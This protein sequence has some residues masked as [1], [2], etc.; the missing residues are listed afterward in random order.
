MT[1]LS[2][3]SILVVDPNGEAGFDLSQSLLSA[4][5]KTHVVQSLNA[6]MTLLNAKR[7]DAV[8]LPYSREPQ[9]VTFCMDLNTRSIPTVFTSEP[10][11]RYPVR[12]RMSG[13]IAAV[14]NLIA[15][16]SDKPELASNLIN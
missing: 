2:N 8:V 3:L 10:P 7:V 11:T 13:A 15:D 4:G 14:Q 6:A 12:R 5:A 9:T 16:R 1:S